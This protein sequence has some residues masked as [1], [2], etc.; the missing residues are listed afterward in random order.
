[1]EQYRG[2]WRA[3]AGDLVSFTTE[4]DVKI[5]SEMIYLSEN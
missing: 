5:I 1:M 3:T 2:G 4:G